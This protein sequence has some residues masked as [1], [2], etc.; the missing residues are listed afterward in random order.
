MYKKDLY[1]FDSHRPVAAVIRNY[2]KE[3]FQALIQIQK[4]SFPPPF[5]SELWWNERQLKNHISLF[6]QGA[7]C[8]E[9]EGEI[10]GSITGMITHFDPQNIQHTW[11][12][13]T[14][15]GYITTHDP[16]GNSLYIV[17]IGVSPR[18]RGLGLG[19]AMMQSMYEIVIELKLERLLGGGR[20]PGFSNVAGEMTASEYL[21]KVVKGKLKDNVISFLLRCGRMPLDVIPGYLDDEESCHYA[22]LME[23]RNPFK[24]S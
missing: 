21:D 12:E 5:P 17:D 15:D 4:E 24:N 2:Q 11:S 19:K 13:V 22:A 8:I 23:W 10:A 9:V 7:L 6:P 18:F 16:E 14:D 3:D 20:M 1:V